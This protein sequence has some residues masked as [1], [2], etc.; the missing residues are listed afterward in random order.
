MMIQSTESRP[1]PLNPDQRDRNEDQPNRMEDRLRVHESIVAGIVHFYRGEDARK[2]RNVAC[3]S[4]RIR[5]QRSATTFCMLADSTVNL[6]N[7][8]VTMSPSAR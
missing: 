2:S 8:P 5:Y 6:P 1:N 4:I 7:I 3:V